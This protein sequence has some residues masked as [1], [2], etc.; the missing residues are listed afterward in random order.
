MGGVF[1][2]LLIT[3]YII[4]IVLNFM[5]P[6]SKLTINNYIAHAGGEIDG[7][8]YTN[9]LEAVEK[10]ISNGIKYI[11]LDLAL[12]SDNYLVCV[13]DWEKFNKYTLGKESNGS[14]PKY[15]DF[16]N[17]R[18]LGKYHVITT[19]IIDSLL[20][21]N[22]DVFLVLDK[23]SNPQII[24]RHLGKYKNRI[25]VECFS[26]NDYYKFEELGYYQPMLSADLQ[27]KHFI[28]IFL[29]VIKNLKLHRPNTFVCNLAEYPNNYNKDILN[30]PLSGYYAAYNC[31]DRKAA[32]QYFKDYSDI[33]LIYIDKTD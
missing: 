12:T 5:S 8:S 22:P 11:E 7:V 9:C 20:N 31:Y 15:S 16:T 25:L 23:I 13:H 4:L 24:E 32:K 3:F 27:N 21:A 2:L 19:E 6:P 28:K 17:R 14:V 29:C 10:S 1:L 18:I 30:K 26:Y 33:K